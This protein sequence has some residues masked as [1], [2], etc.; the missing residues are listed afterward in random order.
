M[1][2]N[3]NPVVPPAIPPVAPSSVYQGC[4]VDPG[5]RGR[6]GSGVLPSAGDLSPS[7]S[8]ELS[9]ESSGSSVSS[10]AKSSA[11]PSL[12][13]GAAQRLMRGAAE[14]LAAL[15]GLDA[16]R[17]PRERSGELAAAVPGL[18]A[19]ADEETFI[20]RDVGDSSPSS[21]RWSRGGFQALLS[22][23]DC[24]EASALD[25]STSSRSKSSKVSSAGW[26]K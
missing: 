7:S 26:F 13:F 3:R 17:P 6:S 18:A 24:A 25:A 8:A 11:R 20:L 12:A 14:S 2:Q 4:Q 15:P 23:E 1:A 16:A 21:S 5:I 10:L 9:G 19:G 22:G